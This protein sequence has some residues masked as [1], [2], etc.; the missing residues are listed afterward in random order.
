MNSRRDD[1]T[2]RRECP[3]EPVDR[4]G[5]GELAESKGFVILEKKMKKNHFVQSTLNLLNPSQ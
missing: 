3:K 4:N 5:D 1:V 2:Q